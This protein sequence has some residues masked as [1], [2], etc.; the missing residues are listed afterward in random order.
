MLELDVQAAMAPTFTEPV[1]LEEWSLP[2]G[3]FGE[4]CGPT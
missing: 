3:A 1:I 2:A 4:S